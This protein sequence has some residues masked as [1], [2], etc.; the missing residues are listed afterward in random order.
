MATSRI[1]R[2]PRDLPGLRESTRPGG[3]MPC[4]RA[5]RS[6][7]VMVSCERAEG[8]ADV[9]VPKKGQSFGNNDQSVC[10]SS[11]IKF[12][13]TVLGMTPKVIE[14]ASQREGLI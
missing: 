4:Q 11:G 3:L 12:T 9:S 10:C 7:N 1:F 14:E 2:W 5:N 6:A 8:L 13:G